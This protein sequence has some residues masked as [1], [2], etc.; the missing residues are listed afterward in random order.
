MWFKMLKPI[1][2]GSWE[3]HKVDSS[4]EEKQIHH[5]NFSPDSRLLQGLGQSHWA[6]VCEACGL[7]YATAWFP[8]PWEQ[9]YEWDWEG[10]RASSPGGQL[11]TLLQPEACQHF[12]CFTRVPASDRDDF[13]LTTFLTFKKVK[14]SQNKNS[15]HVCSGMWAEK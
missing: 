15:N 1:V 3:N 6:R 4:A 10:R 9:C 8:L 2:I 5:C 14:I 11:F 7:S 12:H 13:I